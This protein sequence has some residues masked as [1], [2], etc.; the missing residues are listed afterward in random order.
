MSSLHYQAL[1]GRRKRQRSSP[2]ASVIAL[3]AIAA[4]LALVQSVRHDDGVATM[5]AA[6]QA[7][8]DRVLGS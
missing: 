4:L 8:V 3:M 5:R 6:K 1:S 7:V 2:F